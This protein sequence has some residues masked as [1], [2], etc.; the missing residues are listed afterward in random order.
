[1]VKLHISIGIK[2]TNIL[3]GKKNTF[4]KICNVYPKCSRYSVLSISNYVYVQLIGN[5]KYVHKGNNEMLFNICDKSQKKKKKITEHTS[6]M[7]TDGEYFFCRQS[8]DLFEWPPLMSRP[9]VSFSK[10]KVASEH[11]PRTDY[12]SK[13]LQCTVAV[14]KPT[15]RMDITGCCNPGRHIWTLH[16]A[17]FGVA[18]RH[19]KPSPS[20]SLA[21]VQRLAPC[22]SYPD[23]LRY[24]A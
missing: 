18:G 5:S 20:A 23:G 3:K 13:L 21:D 11:H 6:K 14:Y 15:T 9:A 8:R 2:D 12:I 17:P 7:F 24:F 10:I 19:V 4:A 1:M 16:N 22:M